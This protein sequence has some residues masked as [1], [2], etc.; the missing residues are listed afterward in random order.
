MPGERKYCGTC[1]LAMTSSIPHEIF[2][3]QFI[4]NRKALVIYRISIFSLKQAG[5]K[6]S[7]MKQ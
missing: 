5:S 3:N 2:G 6:E 7:L 1:R 4:E